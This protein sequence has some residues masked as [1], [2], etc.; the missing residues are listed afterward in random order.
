MHPH[1][2]C[3]ET[4]SLRSTNVKR[5]LDSSPRRA[6]PRGAARWADQTGALRTY[7]EVVEHIGNP[8]I[9]VI[10]CRFLFAVT[11][12]A[13]SAYALRPARPRSPI[14]LRRLDAVL[15]VVGTLTVAY[16]LVLPITL[17]SRS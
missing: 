10:E 1:A 14:W 15:W 2:T 12:H 8:V 7:R 16:G 3:V 5:R 13:G 4:T 11:I 6:W 9:F 17:A